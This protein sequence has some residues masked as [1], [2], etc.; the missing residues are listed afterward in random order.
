[1]IY[2]GESV[3]NESLDLVIDI[4]NDGVPKNLGKIVA[5]MYEWEGR[6]ADELELT[7]AD[8]AAVKTKHPFDLKLQTYDILIIII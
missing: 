4:E 2:I 6:I 1:M 7:P 3:F 8:V 5:S